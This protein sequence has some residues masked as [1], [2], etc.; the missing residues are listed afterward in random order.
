MTQPL[1]HK[2]LVARI[3]PD[4]RRRLCHQSDAPGLWRAGMHL[5][6]VAVLATYV[7]AGLPLWWAAL[8][9]LGILLVFLFTGMHECIHRTAFRTDA[10]ND[11]FAALAGFLVLLPPAHFRY[12]HMAHHRHTHDPD[13]DPELADAPRDTRIALALYLTGVPEWAA[14]VRGLLRDALGRTNAGYVPTRGQ[15]RIAHEARLFLAGYG[16]LAATSIATQSW[17]LVWIWLVPLLLGNPFLRV[18]LMAEH[19][20]CPHVANMLQNTRTTFA[21]RAVRWLTWNMPF[22]TEHHAYPAVPF[23]NLPALHAVVRDHLMETTP[24]HGRF[25]LS[26]WQNA[27]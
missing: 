5:G 9:P 27:R 8:V 7:G 4:V 23:H 12:F 1:D 13:L 16:L 19:T 10:L 21:S 2:A 17:V 18:Y 24:S 22:H 14:R 15:D 20:R 11:G 26:E 6:S 25:L 3:P